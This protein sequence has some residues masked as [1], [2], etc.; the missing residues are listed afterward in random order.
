MMNLFAF[1]TD[2]PPITTEQ[3]LDTSIYILEQS[4][5]I[6]AKVY[7]FVYAVGIVRTIIALI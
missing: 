5:I 1:V 6:G 2:P 3:W 4:K 7:P